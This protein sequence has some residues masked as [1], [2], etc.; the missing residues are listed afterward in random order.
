MQQKKLVKAIGLAAT[1]AA[2]AL[3]AAGPASAHVMYNTALWS[4]A[5]GWVLSGGSSGGG[6]PVEWLGTPDGGLPMGFS[7][8]N[9]ALN[10]AVMIHSA[11]QVLEVSA[12][13]A[14]SAYNGA[15]VDLDTANGAWG[16]WQVDPANPTFTRGWAHNTDF[17]LIKS[18]VDT[19]IR[20]EVSKVNPEDNIFNYGIT[21]FEG[22]HTGAIN[23]HSAWNIG[24]ISGVN[25][26]PAK[27]NNPFG[28][29]GLTYLTHG[30]S[31]VVEFFARAGQEYTVYLGGNDINGDIFG[32]P[33]GYKVNVSSVPVPAAAWLFGS[34]LLGLVGMKRRKTQSA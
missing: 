2:M 25:E 11:G 33:Y 8:E 22:M 34:G 23:H 29:S 14:A 15:V 17:G 20:L 26:N 5:D 6:T 24:Y 16:S 31:S 7:A 9:H 30:D 21:V 19:T 18:E 4:G 12:A 10:W 32:I 28:G 13:H 27:V 1:G 3:A